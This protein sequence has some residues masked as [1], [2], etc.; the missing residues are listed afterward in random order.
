MV[1]SLEESGG[2]HDFNVDLNIVRVGVSDL[3][4][5]YSSYVEHTECCFSIFS[6]D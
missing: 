3:E 6:W 5:V 2:E 1:Y 4:E